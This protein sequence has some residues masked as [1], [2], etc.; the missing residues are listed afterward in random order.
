MSKAKT[1]TALFGSL[2]SALVPVALT[3]AAHLPGPFG[4]AVGG[5]LALLTALGVYHAPYAPKAK[6]SR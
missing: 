6:R 2:V 4:A 5:V 1:W 3:V